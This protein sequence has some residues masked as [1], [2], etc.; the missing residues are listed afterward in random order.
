MHGV[1]GSDI[2]FIVLSSVG[3]VLLS[4]TAGLGG[5]W[6][7]IRVARHA[8]H[9]PSHRPADTGRQSSRPSGSGPPLDA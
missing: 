2:V 7:V 6:L 8:W 9:G 1:D 3:F 4:I 5:L